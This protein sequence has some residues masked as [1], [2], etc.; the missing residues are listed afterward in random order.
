MHH[1]RFA[2]YKI[3]FTTILLSILLLGFILISSYIG[4]RYLRFDP[5]SVNFKTISTKVY[6][7]YGTKLWELSADNSVKNTP[8]K[9]SEISPY[10]VNSIVAIEDKT[11]WEN[12]GIDFNGAVRLGLNVF[13]VGGT[14]GSTIS[15][16]VIKVSNESIYN[17]NALDK[18]NEMVYAIKM[19][20]FYTKDQILEMYLNN[21]FM[22]NLNYGIESAS[23]DYFNKKAKDL[24]IAECAYLMGIPQSPGIYNPYG[25]LKKGLARKDLVLKALLTNK[26]INESAYYEALNEKLNFKIHDEEVKAPH[27]VQFL[28]DTY[29][30]YKT[31]SSYT[32]QNAQESLKTYYDYDLHAGILNILQSEIHDSSNLNNSAVIVA[33]SNGELLTMIG[34]TNFFNDSINGK[35]NSA[36][37]LRQ[38]AQLLIPDIYEFGLQ[39]GFMLNSEL[40]NKTETIAVHDIVNPGKIKDVEVQNDPNF[41]ELV[42]FANAQN[43]Y[44]IK[45]A[46]EIIKQAGYKN[47]ENYLIEKGVNVQLNSCNEI[48]MLEGC[49]ITLLDLVKD[50]K[51]RYFGSADLSFLNENNSEIKYINQDWKTLNGVSINNKDFISINVGTDLIFGLWIGNTKGEEIKDFDGTSLLNKINLEIKNYINQNVAK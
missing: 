49:E 36:L 33:R 47:F 13:G 5:K 14:G 18:I 19:N 37:G 39:N 45:P 35:F 32:V 44:L 15:Q 31:S 26:Y 27:F 25:N 4:Y 50:Y 42:S 46:E 23:E 7:R 8:V 28:Q 21:I 48:P 6:D 16:Q 30:Y 24:D 10:C 20:Q 1:Q 41:G 12:I 38:P 11:F 29:G 9:I 2:L 40:S 34:S 3:K 51:K 22:G 17:R 43:S